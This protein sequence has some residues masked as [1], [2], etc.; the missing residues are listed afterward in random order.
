[1]VNVANPPEVYVA[2][3]VNVNVLVW[4]GSDCKDG[5]PNRD[6]DVSD[7]GFLRRAFLE[8][9]DIDSGMLTGIHI[10]YMAEKVAE[11]IGARIADRL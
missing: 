11:R 6:S 7:A 9:P 5:P 4:V 10:H 2:I 8:K 1:M 3:S